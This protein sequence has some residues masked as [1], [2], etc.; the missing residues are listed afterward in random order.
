MK[1][2]F[3]AA[4]LGNG[5]AKRFVDLARRLKKRFLILHFLFITLAL[6]FP[7][8][9]AIARLAPWDF[10]SRL[11]GE[12]FAEIASAELGKTIDP[13]LADGELIADFNAALYGAG[14]GAMLP[15]VLLLAFILVLVLQLVFYALAAVFM[16][17]HRMNSTRFSF[18]ERLSIFIMS[19]TLPVF[20]AALLGIFV[21][22]LHIVVFYFA[23]I[24]TG[25][26]LSRAYDK[27]EKID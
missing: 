14:F 7:V 18:R 6:N 1:D 24:I 2:Y 8:M 25:F 4:A 26:A 21:P 27:A 5:N 19:S 23:E 10:Y 11:Y 16:G 13:A 9:F 12:Q 3:L 17:L 22:A 15:S 20:G